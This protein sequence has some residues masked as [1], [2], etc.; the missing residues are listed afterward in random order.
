MLKEMGHT[1]ADLDAAIVT[2]E[3]RFQQKLQEETAKG[4]NNAGIDWFIYHQATNN[5][6]YNYP[7]KS[8]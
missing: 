8:S 7:G 6:P 1:G 4:Y 5:R 3:Q 2:A